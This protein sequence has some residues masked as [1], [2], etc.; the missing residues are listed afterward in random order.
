[1]TRLSPAQ[2]ATGHPRGSATTGL[3]LS[4][5]TPATYGL[6]SDVGPT[7]SGCSEGAQALADRKNAVMRRAGVLGLVH[8][9]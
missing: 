5:G 2:H 9:S 4:V 3:G 7:G 8:D 1:V 6:F